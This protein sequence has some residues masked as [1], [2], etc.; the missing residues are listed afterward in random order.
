MKNIFLLLFCGVAAASLAMASALAAAGEFNKIVVG[1][2]VMVGGGL[3]IV[4]SPVALIFRRKPNIVLIIALCFVTSFPIAIISGLAATPWVSIAL[5]AL[6][7]LGTFALL[8]KLDDENPESPFRR[9]SV[10]LLPAAFTVLATLFV[11]QQ[12]RLPDDPVVL[13]EM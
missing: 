1:V 11:Y 8:V 10:F 9:K 2:G 3:G 12:N 13:I 5:T 4:L 7:A 6:S